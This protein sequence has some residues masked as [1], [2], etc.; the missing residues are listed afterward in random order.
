VEKLVP[1]AGWGYYSIGRSLSDRFL[2]KLSTK[3]RNKMIENL[4]QDLY[5]SFKSDDE[6]IPC[7]GMTQ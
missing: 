1:V 3:F 6:V 7:Q 2:A 5:M 4:G